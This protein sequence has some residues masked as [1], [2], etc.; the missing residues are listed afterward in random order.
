V[1][2]LPPARTLVLIFIG[3]HPP[4]WCT[5]LCRRE[6]GLRFTA[7]ELRGCGAALAGANVGLDLHG[8]LPPFPCV[9]PCRCRHEHSWGS[10]QESDRR[11]SS[12][13]LEAS[14]NVG[15]DLHCVLPSFIACA[16]AVCRHEHS[17]GAKQEMRGRLSAGLAAGANVGLDLHCVLPSFLACAPAVAGTSTVGVRSRKCDRTTKPRRESCHQRERWS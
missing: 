14:A 9:R 3:N 6:C 10:K 1:P 12:P 11:L 15:L 7:L 4:L 8:D 17:W 2:V 5:A 13:G 16:P